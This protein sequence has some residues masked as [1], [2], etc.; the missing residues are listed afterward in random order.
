MAKKGSDAPS[1]RI[2]KF[3]KDQRIVRTTGSCP[4]GCGRPITNGGAPLITHLNT[5]KGPGKS[6]F[7]RN[8]F[9]G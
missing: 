4:W 9:G 5:C 8:R 2:S 6:V 1:A 3:M 7:R